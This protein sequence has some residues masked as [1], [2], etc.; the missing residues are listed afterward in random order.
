MAG[1][2]SVAASCLS[3]L[4]GDVMTWIDLIVNSIGWLGTALVVVSLA[5]ARVI[6]LHVMNLLSA[7]ILIGYNALIGALPGVGLNVALVLVNAWRLWVLCRPERVSIEGVS[8]VQ[9]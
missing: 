1:R 4:D 8:N 5:Q 2:R 7:V 9:N 3:R 6:R